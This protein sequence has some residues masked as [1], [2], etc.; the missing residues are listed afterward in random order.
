MGQS[1]PRNIRSN[2]YGLKAEMI[3]GIVKSS[4]SGQ[5]TCSLVYVRIMENE[6]S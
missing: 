6:V 2:R 4:V 3:V 5:D 1:G